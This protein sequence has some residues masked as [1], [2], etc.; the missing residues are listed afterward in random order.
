[1]SIMH[2]LI[3]ILTNPFYQVGFA[4]AAG[5]GAAL[6]GRLL[7]RQRSAAL[8]AGLWGGGIALALTLFTGYA[9]NFPLGPH[10]WSALSSDYLTYWTIIAFVVLVV[11]TLEL[12]PIWALLW[13]ILKAEQRIG[14]KG[15]TQWQH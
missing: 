11:L 10:L 13:L 5:M 9:L 1:M 2:L 7:T 8:Q 4:L 12:V 14:D 3:N 15:D 6:C